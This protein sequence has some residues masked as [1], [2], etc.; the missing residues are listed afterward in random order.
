MMRSC[1]AQYVGQGMSPMMALR[2]CVLRGTQ[3]MQ[4]G[5]QQP[6]ADTVLAFANGFEPPSVQTVCGAGNPQIA[7]STWSGYTMDQLAQELTYAKDQRD[8]A[9]TQGD[10]AAE[11]QWAADVQEIWEAMEALEAD[12]GVPIPETT[13]RQGP[14]GT[15]SDVATQVRETLLECSRRGW[16]DGAC[17]V[18]ASRMSKCPDPRQ[19]YVDP[20]LGGLACQQS[21]DPEDVRKAWELECQSRTNGD[22]CGPIKT[23]DGAVVHPSDVPDEI[24]AHPQAYVDGDACVVPLP[25]PKTPGASLDDMLLFVFKNFGG[26]IVV[27]GGP[28]GPACPRC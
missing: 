23:P 14:A 27:L 13:N 21:P 16:K 11:A 7:D 17:S 12:G 8:M 25:A 4:A 18:L 15:C 9:A 22:V 5:L 26:P 10:K 20:S 19:A 3:L 6:I 24:C 28:K 1:I 2:Q